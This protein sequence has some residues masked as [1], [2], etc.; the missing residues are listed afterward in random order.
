MLPLGPAGTGHSEAGDLA[1]SFP[2]LYHGLISLNLTLFLYKLLRLVSG[3]G[4]S[5]MKLGV[6]GHLGF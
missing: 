2:Q 3:T 1:V 4:G 5:C 6:E